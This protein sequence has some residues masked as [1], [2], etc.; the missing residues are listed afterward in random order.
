MALALWATVA[1]GLAHL[2]QAADIVFA[3]AH[4][5]IA[6]LLWWLWRPRQGRQH[7]L[8]LALFVGVCLFLCSDTALDWA[9]RSGG[10]SWFGGG[11]S[12]DYQAWRL[13]P[14]LSP[15]LGVR[16]VLLFCFAQAIHYAV[17]LQ[18]LPDEDRQRVT[19]PTFRTSVRDL[20]RDLGTI[21]L[22]IAVV[23]CAGLAVWAVWDLMRASHGYFRM[24]RFHGHLEV[25]AGTL[26]V[27]ERRVRGA[28]EPGLVH[29]D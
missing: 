23:L 11:M 25:V 27:L 12:L 3:H 22:T 21:G 16:L 18:L 4:N 8:A 1:A 6:V 29:R 13:S 15:D 5:F 7:W 17:W 14:G 19:P 24:A 20:R 10:L 28:R 26:L 9:G 2:G